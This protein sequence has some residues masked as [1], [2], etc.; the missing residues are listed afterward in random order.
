MASAHLYAQE[1]CCVASASSTG[2]I[3]HRRFSILVRCNS[4]VTIY[5]DKATSRSLTRNGPRPQ[6]R[7]TTRHHATCGDLSST[8]GG[9][10]EPFVAL[11]GKKVLHSLPMGL[12]PARRLIRKTRPSLPRSSDQCSGHPLLLMTSAIQRRSFGCH[13]LNPAPVAG[14]PHNGTCLNKLCLSKTFA[15]EAQGAYS[16]LQDY[17][18]YFYKVMDLSLTG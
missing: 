15:P 1:T 14:A 11:L 17:R 7:A 6:Q 2:F 18:F 12:Q 10:L 4:R 8:H 13:E 16:C 3:K 9:H 5:R